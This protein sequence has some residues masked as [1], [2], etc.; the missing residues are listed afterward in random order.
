MFVIAFGLNRQQLPQ[1]QGRDG[2]AQPGQGGIGLRQGLGQLVQQMVPRRPIFAPQL[3]QQIRQCLGKMGRDQGRGFL[4][5]QFMAPVAGFL[6]RIRAQPGLKL[7]GVQ[8]LVQA[9]PFA[10]L[11]GH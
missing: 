1:G 2:L 7:W 6:Q 11:V 3:Q 8:R 9:E 10:G 5:C 4:P